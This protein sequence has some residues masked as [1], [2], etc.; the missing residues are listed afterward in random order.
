MKPPKYIH[1]NENEKEAVKRKDIREIRKW[2]I[3]ALVLEDDTEARQDVLQAV[4]QDKLGMMKKKK[5]EAPE[6]GAMLKLFGILPTS[7]LGL[8]SF[9]ET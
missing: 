4:A 1:L 5:M 3:E 2:C 6:I 7:F 8:K 9:M